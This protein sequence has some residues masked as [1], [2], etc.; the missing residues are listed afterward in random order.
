MSEIN[1]LGFNDNKVPVKVKSL[2]YQTLARS[3]IM[4][5]L[6]AMKIN[7]ND[8]KSLLTKL[9]GNVIK[10]CNSLSQNSKS[11]SLMYAMET[12]PISLH[13]IKRKLGYVAQLVCNQATNAIITNGIHKS[14]D[15]IIDYTG[16]KGTHRKTGAI[17]YGG[18][19]QENQ[20]K[21]LPL[22]KALRHLLNIENDATIKN[23]LDPKRYK[24]G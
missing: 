2:L 18:Q 12:T 10:R 16:I 4:Y 15:D 23:L 13:I 24:R 11:T 19:N 6:E 9:E 17:R 1:T 21:E 20:L 22:V 14:K 8:T 5:G 7:E 3:K